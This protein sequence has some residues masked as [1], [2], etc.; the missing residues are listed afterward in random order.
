MQIGKPGGV[1]SPPVLSPIAVR[2]LPD[3]GWGYGRDAWTEPTALALLALS[4]G[5]GE[6][7]LSLRAGVEL[8]APGAAARRRL[9][10]ES[11]RR[12]ERDLGNIAGSAHAQDRDR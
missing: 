1:A 3:G 2:Q 12:P 5:A 8:A 7:T 11:A 4:T 10:A 6:H 9:A